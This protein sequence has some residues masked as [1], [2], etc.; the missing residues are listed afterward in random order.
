MKW[1]KVLSEIIRE[2]V[3]SGRD[4]LS[5][6]PVQL[7]SLWKMLRLKKEEAKLVGIAG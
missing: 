1:E 5:G 2:N 4:V 7:D 3:Q 6:T